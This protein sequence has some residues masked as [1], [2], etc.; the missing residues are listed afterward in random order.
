[1]SLLKN[2]V[3]KMVS[4]AGILAL[5]IFLGVTIKVVTAWVEPNQEPPGGNISAPLNTSYT[6]QIKQ[7]GLTLNIGGAQYGLIVDKGLV[8]IGTTEPTEKLEV[9]GN[10]K[11]S[12]DNNGNPL[13]KLMNLASPTENSDSANKSY[14]DNGFSQTISMPGNEN[15]KMVITVVHSSY[16][17]T[18]FRAKSERFNWSEPFSGTPIVAFVGNFL[19]GGGFA[20]M[21]LTLAGVD[22]DGADLWIFNPV[23]QHGH[24]FDVK[25]VAI[26]PK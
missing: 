12:G 15:M 4:W 18:E 8:G 22:K 2:I 13:Y 11:L 7:G 3:E 26:G 17:G 14:V 20:E 9:K 6:G 10:I 25:I 16:D 23:N 19:G 5:G 1:M 21:P 24:E